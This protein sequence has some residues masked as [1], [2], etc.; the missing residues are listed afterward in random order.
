LLPHARARPPV[1]GRSWEKRGPQRAPK[2]SFFLHMAFL[3][4]FWIGAGPTRRGRKNPSGGR[5]R[6]T[7]RRHFWPRRNPFLAGAAGPR[8][9]KTIWPIVPHKRQSAFGPLPISPRPGPAR[10]GRV[11]MLAEF[12]Q[13]WGPAPIPAG[14][15]RAGGPLGRSF[16][17]PA[18]GDSGG[19]PP[20]IEAR[21]AGGPPF[22][23]KRGWAGLR[24]RL[25]KAGVL[26]PPFNGPA[27]PKRW[28]G[29]WTGGL[30]QFCRPQRGGP[31][32]VVP[33]PGGRGRAPGLGTRQTGSKKEGPRGPRSPGWGPVAGRLPPWL[34]PGPT[35]AAQESSRRGPAEPP[36]PQIQTAFKTP[37][38]NRRR[39]R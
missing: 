10:F 11:Y 3:P 28:K 34:N 6:P 4:M 7:R 8:D 20:M 21:L 17:F 39:P 1:R 16:F 29:S 14:P 22:P 23:Q 2:I 36:A 31:F 38:R 19:P 26:R 9:K 18:A 27:L 33:R 30:C 15:R 13:K 32:G 12:V 5:P 24:N 35:T 37:P 25:R